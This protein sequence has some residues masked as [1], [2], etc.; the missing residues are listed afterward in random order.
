[1]GNE[2]QQRLSDGCKIQKESQFIFILHHNQV[3]LNIHLEDR[4]AC[5]RMK[6]ICKHFQDNL[7]AKCTCLSFCKQGT[8]AQ[9]SFSQVFSPCPAFI[10]QNADTCCHVLGHFFESF[11]CRGGWVGEDDRYTFIMLYRDLWDQWDFSE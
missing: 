5:S 9:F 4:R 3:F 10:G 6:S 1:M 11:G 2:S 7:Q 8:A